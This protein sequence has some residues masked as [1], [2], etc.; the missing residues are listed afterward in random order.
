MDML[1]ERSYAARVFIG[2]VARSFHWKCQSKR[3]MID[4]LS[5]SSPHLIMLGRVISSLLEKRSHRVVFNGQG[6]LAISLTRNARMC[7]WLH[8]F[9]FHTVQSTSNLLHLINAGERE[10]RGKCRPKKEQNN[11][12]HFSMCQLFSSSNKL[13]KNMLLNTFDS[14]VPVCLV[15]SRLRC[16]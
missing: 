7:H 2:L 3:R 9:A 5:H 12:V 15:A 4:R 8:K 13:E 14:I 10:R 1:I 11:H 6:E 16:R